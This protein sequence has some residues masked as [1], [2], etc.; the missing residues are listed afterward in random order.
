MV[1]HDDLTTQK[2]GIHKI[3]HVAVPV[4]RAFDV[5]TNGWSEWWPVATH[6]IGAGEVT[7]DW[8][9]GGLGVELVDGVLHEWLD[10]VEYDPPRAVGMRWRVT[11]GSPVTDLRVTFIS[12]GDGTRVELTHA[13]WEAYGDRAGDSLG[14]YSDGWDIVLGH[15][16]RATGN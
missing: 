16:A 4:E 5:F 2:A 8:R 10:V 1:D 11:P 15:F 12:D 3:V 7:V 13:G 14:S 6:S 9:V